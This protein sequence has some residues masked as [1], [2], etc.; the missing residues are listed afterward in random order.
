MSDINRGAEASQVLNNPLYKEAH[1]T[2]EERL[3]NELAQAELKPER[4]EYLRQLL[5]MNRKHKAYLEQVMVT[6]KYAEA[7]EERKSMLT[8]AREGLRRVF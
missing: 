5:V 6:G 7:E 4:A 1:Q 3:V 8:L 2:I